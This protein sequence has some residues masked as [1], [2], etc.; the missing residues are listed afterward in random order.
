MSRPRRLAATLALLSAACLQALAAAGE[1]PK[2]I[3]FIGNSYTGG[4]RPAFDQ[5]VK[6]LPDPKPTVAYR[7]HGG[8]LL[9]KHLADAKTIE[10]IEKGRWDIVVLQEQSQAPSLPGKFSKSFHDSVAAFAGLI[11]KAGARP[12]LYMTWGRRDGDAR[13][14]AVN[15]DYETMQNRLSRGYRTAGDAHGIAVAPAGEAWRLV[16]EAD[17]ALGAEL[18]RGD[19]SHPSAKG[20]F[21]SA[22]VLY[23][24]LFGADPP[25]LSR[26]SG[27]AAEEI[28]LLRKAA[29]AAVVAERERARAVGPKAT[30][31]EE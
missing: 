17:A 21:L 30:G 29:Q 27:L 23:A 14:R 4:T 11:R 5:L 19:G 16:R 3:L 28:A 20:A 10:T 15:P 9:E 22:C 2:R 24:T 1:K 31:P 7:L 8:W 6:A 26:L 25:Q 18:H 13:N 12:V